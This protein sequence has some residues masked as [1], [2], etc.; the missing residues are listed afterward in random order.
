MIISTSP[1]AGWGF[2]GRSMK[3][4]Q[5][6]KGRHENRS[7]KESEWHGVAS[8]DMAVASPQGLALF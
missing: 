2:S 6:P 3:R 7:L 8:E 1:L 4:L 5:H